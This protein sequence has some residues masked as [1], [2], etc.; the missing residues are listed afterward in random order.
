MKNPITLKFIKS[1]KGLLFVFVVLMLIINYLSP[2]S[3]TKIPYWIMIKITSPYPPKEGVRRKHS[4]IKSK[5]ILPSE[6]LKINP[7]YLGLKI[8]DYN[9][10]DTI[11]LS[12]F[13]GTSKKLDYVKFFNDSSFNKFDIIVDDSLFVHSIHLIKYDIFEEFNSSIIYLKPTYQILKKKYGNS[14]KI[15]ELKESERNSNEFNQIKIQWIVSNNKIEITF[16][17]IDDYFSINKFQLMQKNGDL[18]FAGFNLVFK[19]N[20]KNEND[21]YEPSKRY[22]AKNL[23]LED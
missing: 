12:E 18:P 23:G 11:E 16:V 20:D 17:L 15:F 19:I 9:F 7:N 8:T 10:I 13:D 3:L 4:E 21:L 6:L 2:I 1:K 22:T 5:L 14:F